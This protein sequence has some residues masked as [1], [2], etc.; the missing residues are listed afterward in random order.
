MDEKLRKQYLATMGIQNWVARE[1]EAVVEQQP[2]SVEPPV[3]SAAP[4]PEPEPP[5]QVAADEPPPWLE[6]VPPPTLDDWAPVEAEPEPALPVRDE[7]AGL[8]WEAL[9]Y[10]V[11]HC[12]AC[13]LHKSRKQTVFGTGDRS[14]GL[15]VIGEA[16]GADEDRQGEPFVGPA[17]QLLDVMLQAIG[18]QREQVFIA[19]IL[20]CRPPG[21]RDPRT[22]EVLQCEPFLKRQVALV[23]PRLILALGGVAAQNL[24][25]SQE[26]VGRMRGREYHLDDI[27]V[28]VTYHPA[29][30]LRSPHQ[31]AR[32]WQ[33]LQRA[34]KLLRG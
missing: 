30:L 32:A 33:D 11:A 29:Y 7:I 21:N 24:L 10:R 27:P 2:E 3:D 22:E 19:N 20:K 26:L 25:H 5:A 14:A 1:A 6:D 28:V 13:E 15:M 12:E 17:G 8:D 4:P 23:R 31:K 34:V 9:A 16:P 18:L